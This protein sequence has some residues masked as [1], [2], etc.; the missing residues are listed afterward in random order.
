[1]YHVK[2][3][4]HAKS[5]EHKPSPT[6]TVFTGFLFS[7]VSRVGQDQERACLLTQRN[8]GSWGPGAEERLLP[9]ETVAMPTG[10]EQPKPVNLG[11]GSPG[12]QV[13]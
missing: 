10:V 12:P 5:E 4:I 13:R 6:G 11:G 8:R 1:M 9:L 7:A 2:Y 3:S